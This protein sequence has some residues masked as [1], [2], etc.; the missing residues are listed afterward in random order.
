MSKV[1]A[2]KFLAIYWEKFQAMSKPQVGK[3]Q[4]VS[5]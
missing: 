1:K 4:F 2:K 5:R 3:I